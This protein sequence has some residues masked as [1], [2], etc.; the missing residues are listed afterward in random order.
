M[1]SQVLRAVWW[2]ITVE[3]AGEILTWSLLGNMNTNALV[4]TFLKLGHAFSVPIPRKFSDHVEFGWF[5][6]KYC[7]TRDSSP[8]PTPLPQS[9][10]LARA[11]K[12]A[13]ATTGLSTCGQFLS[14]ALS[15]RVAEGWSYSRSWWEG[16]TSSRF[17]LLPRAPTIHRHAKPAKSNEGNSA[18]Q[19]RKDRTRFPVIWNGMHVV[20]TLSYPGSKVNSPN[21]SK[22]KCI[23]EV[24][25][26]GVIVII[27]HLSKLWKARFSILCDVIFLA[28]LQGNFDIDHSQEWKG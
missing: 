24:V 20:L 28:R 3:A 10:M 23:S 26:I 5:Q 8:L 12:I 9:H 21:L 25:R 22:K 11:P 7:S 19:W 13:R 14:I 6:H 2:N 17:R 15:V 4:F 18:Q 16:K 27:F 1:K